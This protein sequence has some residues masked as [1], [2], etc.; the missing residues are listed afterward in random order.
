MDIV[1]SLGY[2]LAIEPL[3]LVPPPSLGR[4]RPGSR[5]SEGSFVDALVEV[6][7]REAAREGSRTVPLPAL[8]FLLYTEVNSSV[9]SGA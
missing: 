5:L 3:V 7:A 4:E 1:C 2:L 6:A 8:S 9:L